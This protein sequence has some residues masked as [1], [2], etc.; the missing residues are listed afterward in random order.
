MNQQQIWQAPPNALTLQP[1]EVHVWRVALDQPDAVVERLAET[2]APDEASRAARFYFDR[3]RRHY[4][5]GR[6]ILRTLLGRYL[7][8]PPTTLAFA[9]GAQNKPTLEQ[10]VRRADQTDQAGLRFNLSHSHGQALYGFTLRREIGIDIEQIRPMDDAEA[11]A[12]RF[13]SARDYATFIALQ[14]YERPE[15]FFNC[16]TRKEAY[17]KAL[18]EGLSHPLDTFDVTLTPGDPA[19][20]LAVRGDPQ[21]RERW[22]MVSL[23]P[24]AGYI[25]ALVVEGQGWELRCFRYSE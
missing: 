4:T 11:I 20:I 7:D 17:I 3:D 2:L 16:W 18:G 14:P 15:G 1:D 22:S 10:Q 9:Y 23:T 24:L 25:G 19:R 5:V 21:E 12:E 6:G 8:Q 13:F